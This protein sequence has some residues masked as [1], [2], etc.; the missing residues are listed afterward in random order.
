MA[1]R[2]RGEFAAALFEGGQARRKDAAPDPRQLHTRADELTIER[3]LLA[4]KLEPWS[5]PYAKR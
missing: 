4:E 5:G 2:T 3:D 1:G